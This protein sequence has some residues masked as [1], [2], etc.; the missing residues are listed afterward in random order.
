MFTEHNGIKLEISNRKIYDNTQIHIIKHHMEQRRNMQANWN[1]FWIKIS[2]IVQ[3]F[4]KE[5]ISQD[6]VVES[7]WVLSATITKPQ[8]IAEKP[9]KKKTEAYENRFLQL[10]TKKEP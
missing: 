8:L 7:P 4:V 9:S 1:I 10:D 5:R 6:S 3:I 2:T